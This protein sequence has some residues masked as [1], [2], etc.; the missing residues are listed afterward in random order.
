[1]SGVSNSDDDA[2][3]ERLRTALELAELAEQML[4]EKLR[5]DDRSLS[6]DD[7]EALVRAWYERRAGAEAGDADGTPGAWPRR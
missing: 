7:E 2:V 4:R 6:L 3:A 5:R 1:M